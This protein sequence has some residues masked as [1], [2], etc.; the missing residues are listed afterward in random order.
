MNNKLFKLIRIGYYGL[1][2]FLIFTKIYM[3]IIYYKYIYSDNVG[4]AFKTNLKNALTS[5]N[6]LYNPKPNIKNIINPSFIEI[7]KKNISNENQLIESN[8]KYIISIT[9]KELYLFLCLKI[10]LIFTLNS[11]Y[12]KKYIENITYQY[13]FININTN[14]I[15]FLIIIC[16]LVGISISIYLSIKFFKMRKILSIKDDND[17]LV[18]LKQGLLYQRL[19]TITNYKTIFT[20]EIWT[21]LIR[22]ATNYNKNH[23]TNIIN[24]DNLGQKKDLKKFYEDNKDINMPAPFNGGDNKFENIYTIVSNSGIIISIISLILLI[25]SIIIFYKRLK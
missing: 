11:L 21:K 25:I 19:D 8:R 22:I 17:D 23:P 10:I 3:F 13:N 20:D 5:Y 16:V 18:L 6:F 15:L 24:I 14:I 1:L 2:L 9:N 12:N 7:Y 4:S